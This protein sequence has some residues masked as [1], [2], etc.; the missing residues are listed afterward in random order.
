[1][2]KIYFSYPSSD[3]AE[4]R[5]R[6]TLDFIKHHPLKPLNVSLVD[7]LMENP[8]IIIAYGTHQE[9]GHLVIPA[10]KIIFKRERNESI[11][12]NTNIYTHNNI[13][14]YSVEG[15]QSDSGPLLINRVFQ[16]DILETI[17]FHISR[18][19]E[20]IAN[21]SKNSQAGWLLEKEHFLIKNK[22]QVKPVV[23]HLV[24]AFY[25]IISGKYI[26]IRST[27]S[28]S[29]DI[30][31]LLRFTP[32]PKFI[33]SLA[34]T[35]YYRRGIRQFRKSI[36]YYGKMIFR[37][38]P[39]PYD[40]FDKL[41]REEPAWKR[42]MVF[43]MAGGRTPFDNKYRLTDPRLNEIIKIA[44][45]CGYDIGIHPSYDAGFNHKMYAQETLRLSAYLNQ[46]ITLNRQ[47]WLRMNWEITPYLWEEN[48]IQVDSS[49]GYN[50]YLGYR[51]GTGF[52]YNMYDFK[53]ERAFQWIEIPL[54]FMES[55]AMHVSNRIKKPLD[56]VM[57]E[58]LDHCKYNTHIMINFHNS[59]FD[60]LLQTGQIIDDFYTNQLSNYFGH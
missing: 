43:V 51:C 59:N 25:E 38:Y 32:F 58:F 31:V 23:D 5:I 1:M 27:Y 60:P 16:F 36:G 57:G 4:K 40:V 48:G 15:K 46:P 21:S 13:K 3:V 50:E 7:S 39:D 29:H 41:F 53:N 28:I 52:P 35:I 55:A 18:Y 54:V 14:L 30:D 10:Q 2:I 45:S 42:K 56:M 26:S 24:K 47:H 20:I 6:Y 49:I 34:A 19:E 8:Q 37:N 33:K 17:F 12:F 9:N 44:V 22:L 11:N